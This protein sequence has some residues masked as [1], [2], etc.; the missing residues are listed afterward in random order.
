MIDEVP[1]LAVLAARAAGRTTIRDASELRVKESDRIKA[2]ANN[3]VAIGVQAKELPDGLVIEGTTQP[4]AGQV[5]SRMDH[6]IA[7]AFGVL[8]H[9]KH[10]RIEVDDP[11]VVAV[12][13]PEFWRVLKEQTS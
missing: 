1:A 9:Q 7:M 4:L 8:A 3:L 10:N 2:L 12:S 5:A 11:A 13:F 6:R